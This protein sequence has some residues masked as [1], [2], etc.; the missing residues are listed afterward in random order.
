MVKQTLILAALALAGCAPTEGRLTAAAVAQGYANAGRALPAK[1]APD[2]TAPVGTVTPGNEAWAVSF[3]R[4]QILIDNRDDKSINCA[5]WWE[6]Y[7]S[8]VA[9]APVSQ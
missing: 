3:R 8:G 6:D 5:K 7:T 1:L 2:C 9:K 4:Q